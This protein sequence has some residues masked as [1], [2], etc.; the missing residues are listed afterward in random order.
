VGF[1][2]KGGTQYSYIALEGDANFRSGEQEYDL[3][4]AGRSM[5]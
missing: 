4:I 2:I 3:R 1:S 5:F